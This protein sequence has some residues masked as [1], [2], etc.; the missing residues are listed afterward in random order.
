MW[1][2]GVHKTK[3]INWLQGFLI[4]EA[5]SLLTLLE[6]LNTGEYLCAAETFRVVYLQ[7]GTLPAGEYHLYIP[8]DP[9]DK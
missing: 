1:A 5:E 6:T 7:L 2:L 9:L 8:P 3:I 4:K